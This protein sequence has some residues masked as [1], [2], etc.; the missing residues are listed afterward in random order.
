MRADQLLVHRG[1][2]PTRAV[3]QRLIAAGVQW[4]SSISVNAA[5]LPIQKNGQDLPV[6]ADIQ[7]LD[8]SDLQFVSRAGLKL[9]GALEQAGIKVTNYA[10]L[11]V[12]QSTGGFTDCLLQAGAKSVLGIDVGHDQLAP[13]LALDA[14][15]MALQGVNARDVDAV[16]DA[17]GLALGRDDLPQAIFDL[18][19]VDLS[20]ISQTHILPVILP[21]LQK[22]GHLISLVKPQFELSPTE[23]GKGGLV[24]AKYYDKVKQRL[25]DCL[26][27]QGLLPT[28]WLESPILGG[29]GNTEFFVIVQK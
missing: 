6:H 28:M 5:W 4:R 9:S 8:T 27:D 15:V 18:V 14:R 22:G 11:D 29:D 3:A 19:V 23:I 10:C 1:F 12:G 2:A 7:L 17:L 26:Q 20:F 24:D 13:S 16:H 25:N 21:L